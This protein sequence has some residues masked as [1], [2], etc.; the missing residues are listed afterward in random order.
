MKCIKKSDNTVYAVKILRRQTGTNHEIEILQ[1]ATAGQRP[2]VLHLVE[3]LTDSNWTYLVT[4]WIDGV[5]LL[6]YFR[7]IALNGRIVYKAFDALWTSV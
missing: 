6:E 3:V 7:K 2:G 5:N 1:R 4:E